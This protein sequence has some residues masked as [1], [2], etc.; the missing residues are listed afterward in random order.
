[1]FLIYSLIYATI[2]FI[3]FVPQ[4]LKRPKELRRKW[5]KE[6]LGYLPQKEASLWVHAV[7]V[8]E[9]G[10]SIPLLNKL[11]EEYP[12]IPIILSTV[13]DTGQKVACS[14]AP[15]GT[16][17]VYLPYDIGCAI[18]KCLKR[19]NPKLFITIETELWPN[20][21]RTLG[22]RG[23][24]VLILN[25]RISE[26]SSKGYEKI[27]FFMKRVF[28]YVKVF[29]MQSQKDAERVIRIGA[30][31]KKVVILG[32]FKFDGDIPMRIP[33]WALAI[34]GLVIVAGSTHRG[35]EEII[36]NAY[37]KN[38]EKFPGLKLLLA[39]RHPNRFE[40][41]ADLLT[42]KGIP[43]LKRS[44]LNDRSIEVS[45]G[46]E[47]IFLKKNVILLD[48]VGELPSV[49][50]I[51]DIAIVGKSFIGFG[52]QNPLE[53]AFWGKPILCGP[54]MENFPFVGEFFHEGAAFEVE[55]AGLAK[56]IEELLSSPEKAR[57]AG[58]KGKTLYRKN[59]GSVQRAMKIVRKFI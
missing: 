26:E 40:E 19:V 29:G 13:T 46:S 33:P 14:K 2:I 34:K 8:G 50:G 32:N 56:K 38:L 10:A 27:S 37:C 41:V 5:L 48:S 57:L 7:S 17:V 25:G 22:D 44:D 59:S 21:F 51:A 15:Q 42:T 20:M 6:K 3:V 45:K 23:V 49:Y 55:P 9:V 53:P 18:R 47:D 11:R 43:F 4:Y 1:M 16:N 54:H 12:G 30:D 36:L 58:E 31:E 35:E 28:A 24:P 52:G 39:P